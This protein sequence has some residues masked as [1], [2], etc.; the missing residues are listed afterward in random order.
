MRLAA[1]RQTIPFVLEPAPSTVNG[2]DSNVNIV[3]TR[4][5]RDLYTIGVGVDAVKLIK[6]MTLQNKSKSNSSPGGST[7]TPEGNPSQPASSTQQPNR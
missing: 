7:K 6:T 5:N 4:S 1:P 3:T 2:F